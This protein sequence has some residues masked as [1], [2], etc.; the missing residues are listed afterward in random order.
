M[1][2]T[3]PFRSYMQYDDDKKSHP[4][5]EEP[6]TPTAGPSQSTQ[7]AQTE[8][9]V[10]PE[11]APPP[12]AY[13]EPRDSPAANVPFSPPDGPPP[14]FAG[15]GF[16]YTGE[17]PTTTG[18]YNPLNPAPPCFARPLP[19]TPSRTF[20][21]WI[22]IPAQ[23]RY[24]LDSG[25]VPLYDVRALSPHDV[26]PTDFA[27]FLSDCHVVGTL[28]SGSRVL[29]QAVPVVNKF[30]LTGRLLS[31]AVQKGVL[32]GKVKE[33]SA[34]VDAWNEAFFK[35]RGVAVWLRQGGK[36]ISGTADAK[37]LSNHHIAQQRA[38]LYRGRTTNAGP[39]SS[40]RQSRSAS[41]DSTNSF[42]MGRGMH[43]RYAQQHPQEYPDSSRRG[44]R[45]MA[46]QERR[47]AH[48][49]RRQDHRDARDAH[50]EVRPM[51]FSSQ[52]LV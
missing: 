40:N 13:P 49:T 44:E 9:T 43:P 46:R 25:F 5:D 3:N 27:R 23:T 20:F 14:A 24:S 32:G 16:T 51:R 2:S 48:R 21:P 34:L 7:T 38:D 33:V 22:T 41:S 4:F 17:R 47:D 12:Y 37:A 30:G 39:S 29:A 10:P 18:D 45:R 15:E 42:D 8:H 26:L 1:S 35:P 31:M 11:S 6:E 52:G 36:R 50:R 19:P 28:S